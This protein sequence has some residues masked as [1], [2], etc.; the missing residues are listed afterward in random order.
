MTELRLAEFNSAD[1]DRIRGLLTECLDVPRWVENVLAGRPYAERDALLAAAETEL[2]PGEIRA[3]MRVHPRIG[4]RPG[5]GW[6]RSE[7]S[8]V[9][10]EAAARFRAANAEYERRFGHVYLVCASGRSG[11]ELLANLRERLG[12]DPD[13][14]LAVAGRELVRIAKLRL[15][16]AVPA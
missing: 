1:P 13:T 4:E 8:G 5:G 12:N 15:E 3:A 9:D 14:E 11:E 16:R 7:Q 10:E 6:A 2:R